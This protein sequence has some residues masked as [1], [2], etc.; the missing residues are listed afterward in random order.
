MK[1]S[2]CPRIFSCPTY[3]ASVAGRSERSI[4]SS[5]TEEGFAEISRSVST[6]TSGF[7]QSL[8]RGA[9][10]LGDRDSRR[11]AFHG[12]ERLLLAVAQAHERVHH[13][14]RAAGGLGRD[15]GHLALQFQQQ[16][17]GGFLADAG[18]F[19]EG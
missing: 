6:A 10:A 14:A 3:S 17:L 2:S 7:C 15:I 4:C 13:I 8:Q 12:G 9:D 18:N 19:R 11:Q 16:P 5:C 1:I